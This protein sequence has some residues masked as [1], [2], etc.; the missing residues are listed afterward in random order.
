MNAAALKYGALLALALVAFKT[1]E[2]A[3]FSRNI[4]LDLYLGFVALAFLL[5]GAGLG[6]YIRQRRV[7]AQA[8]AAPPPGQPLRP[9]EASALLSCRELEVL[10]LIA[11]GHTNQQIADRLFVSINTVKTHI[12]N[13]YM[14]LEVSNRTGAVSQAKLLG[15]LV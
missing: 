5:V 15:I 1:L 6:L 7:R 8:A 11:E 3:Y 9:V 12:S 10:G 13:I 14:K 4:S 2:Y